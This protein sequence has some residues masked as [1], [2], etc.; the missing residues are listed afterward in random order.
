M[1]YYDVSVH[2]GIAAWARAHD[3]ELDTSLLSRRHL[4][5]CGIWQA[6]VATVDRLEVAEWLLAL[7]RPVVRMLEAVSPALESQV[8][9][10]PKVECDHPSAGNAG[11]H[12]LLTLGDVH[13]GFY[14]HTAAADARAIQQGFLDTMRAAGKNPFL[15]D[16]R[17][18]HPEI[19]IG[20]ASPRDLWLSWL[21]QRLA[22]IPLP[23][24]IMAEDDRFALALAQTARRLGLAMPTD[25]AILG[26]DD[27]RLLLGASPIGISS[28]DSDLWSVGYQAADLAA[29]LSQGESPP[30]T[31]IR[32]PARQVVSRQ[33]TATF[34]GHHPKAD[35]A[36]RYIRTHFRSPLTAESVAGH[37][38]LTTRGLHKI[39]AKEACPSLH[40][41]ILRLRLEA[42]EQLLA[43][44]TLKL[45]AIAAETGFGNSK[46]LC[47]VFL[48]HR[49]ITPRQCRR[50]A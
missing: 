12:H 19:P 21:E 32:I 11:A 10:L 34:H 43:E 23:A 48:K 8:R 47:R 1:G 17:A 42:A 28:V 16:F 26:V 33:S 35:E 46:N 3:W 39:L 50:D 44:S 20:Q 37:V 41:E 38:G 7:E 29:R 2:A 30:A 24:A 22:S 36:M 27:N 49:G 15:L 31:P 13:Y 25:L 6:V 45:E 9:H 5:D 40:Q 14:C 4:P 18:D